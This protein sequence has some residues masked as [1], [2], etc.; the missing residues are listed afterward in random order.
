MIQNSRAFESSSLIGKWFIATVKSTDD[1]LQLGRVRILVPDLHDGLSGTDLPYAIC[2]TPVFRGSLGNA[3]YFSVPRVGSRVLVIFDMG[4]IDSPI[5]I[6]ELRDINTKITS[7]LTDYPATYGF[8]DENGTTF[9]VDTS[10][11][12]L[13][14]KHQGST[15][16]IDNNGNVDIT[17]PNTVITGNAKIT[18]IL[19]VE[20]AVTLENTLHVEGAITADSTI[21]STGD[22]TIEGVNIKTHTHTGVSTGSGVTGPPS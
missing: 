10:S 17:A 13:T 8:T 5:I 22:G 4:H 2:M 6:G 20:G 15:I 1:P 7:L 12:V 11:K 18:G 16:I 21:E 19:D 3:G 9:N 14:I